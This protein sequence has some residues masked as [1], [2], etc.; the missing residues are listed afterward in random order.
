[1]S[2]ARTA[3][4]AGARRPRPGGARGRRPRAAR[5]AHA[6]RPRTESGAGEDDLHVGQ[7]RRRVH[8]G[9]EVLVRPLLG[10]AQHDG[11]VAQTQLPAQLGLGRAGR[12]L[13]RSHS[14]RHH[15]QPR[16]VEPH[17]RHEVVAHGERAGDHQVHPPAVELH[18]PRAR[19]AARLSASPWCSQMRSCRVTTV[20]TRGASAGGRRPG[21][22]RGR[23]GGAGRARARRPARP[24][25]RRGFPRRQVGGQR[26]P[27]RP[28]AAC[29]AP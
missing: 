10:H 1:M 13:G 5:P 16:R 27:G 22:A 18:E 14:V 28:P 15:V 2:R 3:P 25:A 12:G 17:R 6:A 8:Q 24:R 19:W 26:P 29:P 9:G 21:C 11:T 20:A 4:R 7:L 23:A